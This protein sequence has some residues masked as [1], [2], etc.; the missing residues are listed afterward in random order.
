MTEPSASAPPWPERIEL[1]EVTPIN[2]KPGNVLV[3]HPKEGNPDPE[4]LDRLRDFFNW[5][6]PDNQVAIV[7]L[8]IGLDVVAAS[9]GGGA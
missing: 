4:T 5:M 7:G 1:V 3:V 6:F 9:E 8:P 2:L